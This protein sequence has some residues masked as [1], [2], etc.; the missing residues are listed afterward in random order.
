M[1][2]QACRFARN[3]V[4]FRNL[5]PRA[6]PPAH[7]RNRR[8]PNRDSLHCHRRHR[9][10]TGNRGPF[11][12]SRPRQM[13]NEPHRVRSQSRRLPCRQPILPLDAP[14]ARNSRRRVVARS[15][16]RPKYHAYNYVASALCDTF[17]GRH[18]G[19]RLGGGRPRPRKPL[20]RGDACA[21]PPRHTAGGS[22]RRLVVFSR[23]HRRERSPPRHQRTRCVSRQTRTVELAC[24]ARHRCRRSQP[25]SAFLRVDSRPRLHSKTCGPI[26]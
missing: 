12:R 6:P 9:A 25:E 24:A 17:D 5:P 16:C 10:C 4:N 7:S 20:P 14:S 21:A 18:R 22:H 1:C 11:A 8:R 13:V 2:C 15:A 26:W 23:L 3:V 19:P